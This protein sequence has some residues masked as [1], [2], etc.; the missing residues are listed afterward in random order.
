MELV[1]GPPVQ[2]GRLTRA[3]TQQISISAGEWKKSGNSF[4]VEKEILL[5]EDIVIC[6][7]PRDI[8]I[9]GVVCKETPIG[10]SE[11]TRCCPVPYAKVEIHDVD[12]L[13]F[14]LDHPYTTKPMPESVF[15]TP[16]EELEMAGEMP[17]PPL[18]PPSPGMSEHLSEAMLDDSIGYIDI[19][20]RFE[21]LPLYTKDLLAEAYTDECG[22]FCVT[23]TWYPGCINPDIDP[24]LLFKVS[25]TFND[26]SGP[27]THTLYAEGYSDTHWDTADY[28]G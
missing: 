14:A 7:L 24:D 6:W 21:H 23:F 3:A 8:K 19:T 13:I 16:F 26:G 5:P 15:E 27:V 2:E 11:K 22:E 4:S 10:D 25:Q 18:P 17:R 9:C 28:H 1:V 20:K 12:P